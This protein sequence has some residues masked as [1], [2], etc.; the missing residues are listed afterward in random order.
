[1][2]GWA[3]WVGALLLLVVAG[4]SMWLL[5]ESFGSGSARDKARLE[6]VKV[7]G[8]VV[9]GSG[10]G[11]AL[12]LAARRQRA[13]ELSLDQKERAAADTR[14]DAAERRVTDLYASAAEQLGSDKAPVRL[15]ALH[16]LDRLGE[17]NPTHRQAVVDL[18]CAY[19]R[20]PFT[21]P[22]AETTAP[23]ELPRRGRVLRLG[24]R[25]PG[26][27]LNGARPS[28]LVPIN[29]PE[30]FD[31]REE[32]QQEEQVRRT[33]QRLIGTHIRPDPDAGGE[34]TNPKFWP[35]IS[36]DLT[37][38][39]LQDWSMVDCRVHHARLDRARFHGPASFDRAEFTG[40]VRAREVV[41]RDEAWFADTEFRGFVRLDRAEFHA[42]ADFD[43]AVFHEWVSLA[44]AVFHGDR[45]F[46]GTRPEKP[47][48]GPPEPPT[49]GD[50]PVPGTSPGQYE[51]P[52]V[53]P[54]L[55]ADPGVEQE[56]EG[57]V[58]GGAPAPPPGFAGAAD[59]SDSRETIR[60][61]QG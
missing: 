23:E 5:L 40:E 26:R 30:A 16:A 15:A 11:V 44:G 50:P 21:P 12:L 45:S 42:E 34:P 48:Q 8:S 3:I 61:M 6:A 31:Q 54:D 43:R 41:F 7:A 56:P 29:G 2:P 33:A 1:M 58:Q 60:R 19:L 57:R 52:W 14:H 25:P 13:T 51:R 18:L 46:D 27:G 4:L 37:T 39:T 55:L 22:E 17:N 38:A 59:S 10:G 49:W 47:E 35:D 24:L 20:M 32:Q 53:P 9:L 36:L 28:S